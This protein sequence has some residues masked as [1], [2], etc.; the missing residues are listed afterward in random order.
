MPNH[1][2]TGQHEKTCK[3]QSFKIV[4]PER[5]DKEKRVFVK[6]TFGHLSKNSE[7]LFTRNATWSQFNKTF[8]VV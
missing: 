7:N 5:C 4:S 6:I 1:C 8:T 2:A 3:G